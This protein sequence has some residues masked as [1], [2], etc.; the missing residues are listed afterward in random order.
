M[1]K[2]W[3]LLVATAVVV[4]QPTAATA[5]E[6]GCSTTYAGSAMSPAAIVVGVGT[7][8]SS[9]FTVHVTNT[10]DNPT[11]TVNLASVDIV[12]GKN[13]PMTQGATVGGV[14]TFVGTTTWRSTTLDVEHYAGDWGSYIDL[15]SDNGPS[16]E[17]PGESFQVLRSAVLLQK[18]SH[19][20]VAADTAVTITG[21]LRRVRW[22][23]Q[24]LVPFGGQRVSLQFQPTGGAYS[25]VKTVRSASNGSTY[26]M[27]SVGASGCYRLVSPASGT[28]AAAAS[29]PICVVVV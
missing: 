27:T 29:V 1:L 20:V 5:G 16:T 21:S 13:V 2:V 17:G 11:V 28:T 18:V 9:T 3:G 10:C 8:R 6:A 15:S 4:A 12:V 24:A 26:T 7:V 19:S 22:D 14:T 25:T 23:D